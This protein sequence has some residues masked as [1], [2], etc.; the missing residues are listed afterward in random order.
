MTYIKIQTTVILFENRY[1]Q[2]FGK[3]LSYTFIEAFENSIKIW[4]FTQII[5]YYTSYKFL[6]SETIYIG[7]PLIVNNSLL[8]LRRS[9]L[10]ITIFV[11]EIFNISL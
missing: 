10:N 7:I 5:L 6:Y 3:K 2:I 9:A 11:L 1:C 4:N 8:K